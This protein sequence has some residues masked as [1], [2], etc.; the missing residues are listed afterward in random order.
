MGEVSEAAIIRAFVDPRGTPQAWV[1]NGDDAAIF[2]PSG[3]RGV[4][5][6]T[7]DFVED[8]H[9]TRR[10]ISPEGL[11]SRLVAVNVSDVAAMGARPRHL[12]LSV[13][14]PT[15]LSVA[16]VEALARG[17]H[18]RCQAEDVTVL[19]GNVSRSPGPIFLSATLTGEV[20]AK[21]W[22]P[23]T[24]ARVGDEVWMSGTPGRAAAGLAVA[25][26]HGPPQ[27]RDPAWNL[28]EAWA[29]PP[30]RVALALR[31]AEAS[32]LRAMCDVSDGLGTDLP[33]LLGELGA[34]LEAGALIVEPAVA[35]VAAREG[36]DPIGF[37]VSGGEDYELLMIADPDARTALESAA[38]ELQVPLRRLGR[39]RES[40]GVVLKG[41]KGLRPVGPGHDHFGGLTS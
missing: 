21:R 23:R 10:L 12:F 28:Y 24:G 1:D 19:G 5:V 32:L 13:A 16:A 40:S 17:L 6:T 7:D 29:S 41:P 3:G 26:Q 25:L 36:L 14:L 2:A 8:V 34:E 31:L 30:S 9:F 37:A 39:V 4:V 33:R 35:A 20:E 38:A 11:G 22:V 15:H 27:P 18:R